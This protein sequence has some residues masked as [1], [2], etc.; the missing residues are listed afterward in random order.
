MFY[1]KRAFEN[2]ARMSL[3]LWRAFD[4][5]VRRKPPVAAADAG[6]MGIEWS[7]RVLWRYAGAVR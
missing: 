2:D 7:G 3:M 5:T 1:R 6:A 4:K